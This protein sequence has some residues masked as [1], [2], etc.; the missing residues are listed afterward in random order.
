M[1]FSFFL[2]LTAFGTS[3]FLTPLARSVALRFGIMDQPETRKLHR[4]PVPLLGGL[5]IYFSVV[6]AILLF[7]EV[8]Q[9][10]SPQAWYQILG[11]LG[12]ASMLVMVGALDD[13]GHLHPQIKLVLGMP[14]AAALLF[15][16]G[17]RATAWPGVAAFDSQTDAFFVVSLALTLLWVLTITASFS[18]LDHMDGLC[19]GVAAIASGFFWI[20]A[21]QQGQILGGSFAAAMLGATLG[22][23]RWNFNPAHIF[24]GDSGALFI[25]F[26]MATL[27]MKMEFQ[28]VPTTQSWI[29]PVLILGVPIFD[30]GLVTISRIRRGLN[31]FS[32]PGQDHT[33]HRLA[34]L[35]LG[36]RGAV[37]LLHAIAAILG[38]TAMVVSELS[39][40][41]SYLLLALLG[42]AGLVAII[43]L[44]RSAHDTT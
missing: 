19:P 28:D 40:G 31:P 3:F 30:T 15:W 26:M 16:G 25:G 7:F 34:N 21:A 41:Q 6:V 13:R 1:V 32:S 38:C 39:L 43:A 2:F 8:I 10:S 24:M 11:I 18:I 44:E 29:I 35:G 14:L 20:L 9:S 5:A 37:I 22:F 42:F 12:G 36:Q 23:L 17:V 27:G 4:N 33:A